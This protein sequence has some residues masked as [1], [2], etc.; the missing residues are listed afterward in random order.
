[1]AGDNFLDFGG[2]MAQG[3]PLIRDILSELRDSPGA[4]LTVLV[5]PTAVFVI[6]SL[7]RIGDSALSAN[8]FLA[9]LVVLSVVGAALNQMARGLSHDL[10]GHWGEHKDSPTGG[11]RDLIT[12]RAGGTAVLS[13]M[14]I[15]PLLV[16]AHVISPASLSAGVWLQLAVALVIGGIPIML[17]GLVLALWFAGSAPSIA[18]FSY[19]A[20]ALGGGLILPPQ[21]MPFFVWRA[22]AILPSRH[23]GDV[24]WA[25]V[26]GWSLPAG[27]WL[28]LIGFTALFGGAALWRLRQDNPVRV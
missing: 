10:S 22:A 7:T 6:H 25:P 2:R 18:T 20:L 9:S 16:V 12:A 13:A 17:Y 4:A 3:T 27:N 14:A 24:V 21:S 19:F 1:V 28:W 8:F 5:L 26:L 23:Y 11:M 15:T